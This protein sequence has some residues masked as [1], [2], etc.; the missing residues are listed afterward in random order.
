MTLKT[1]EVRKDELAEAGRKRRS[2][3]RSLLD[4]GFSYRAALAQ[5]A[6]RPQDAD[7]LERRDNV[8]R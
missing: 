3:L 6:S 2:A 8:L 1:D 4:R 7:N 5:V